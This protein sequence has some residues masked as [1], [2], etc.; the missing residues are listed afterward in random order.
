MNTFDTLVFAWLL[1][2][3]LA[4]IIGYA[5]GRTI[6]AMNLGIFLGPIG[7]L[8]ALAVIPRRSGNASEEVRILKFSDAKRQRPAARTSERQLRRAA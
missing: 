1:S 2:S 7:F 4:T 6:E 3:G 8:V 5:R